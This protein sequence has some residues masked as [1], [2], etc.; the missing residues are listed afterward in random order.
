MFIF[1]DM[2]LL[3]SDTPLSAALEQHPTLIP[4]VSRFGIRLGL[5]EKSV[6]TVCTEHGIDAGFML[7]LMNTY[8]FEEYFPEQ[9]LKSF[10]VSQL[11]DYLSKTN[12][13][14]LHYQLPNIERHLGS[15]I[16][17]GGA[18]NKNLA[19]LGQFFASFKQ[20][21]TDSID[22]DTREWFPYCLAVSS[23]DAAGGTK[24]VQIPV[25]SDGE[26][27]DPAVSQ[28]RDLRSI[29]VRHLSG[30]Y[31]DNLAYAVIFAVGSIERDIRQHNRIRNRVLTPVIDALCR[32]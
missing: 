14:Y 2:A 28:L 17:S 29:M 31:N 27:E 3:T 26:G 25:I 32:G 24:K 16:A 11:V 9:K 8:L 7:T 13:Y 4:L 30:E 22:Y 5:G 20:S 6:A 23:G 18:G 12:A 21:L 10:H 19:L 1:T 15:L